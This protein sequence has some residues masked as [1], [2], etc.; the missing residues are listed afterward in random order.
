VLLLI[1][2]SILVLFSVVAVTFALVS[3]RF[4][5]TSQASSRSDQYSIDFKDQLDDAARQILRGS[6]NPLSVLTIHSLLEDMY[7][8]DSF[9][10]ASAGVTIVSAA[11]PNNGSAVTKLIDIK[12]SG[13]IPAPISGAN[14]IWH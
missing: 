9:T 8:Y 11:V 7:G 10:N 4:R 14:G 3:S 13:A 6:K 5:T 1:V 2:L 12:L